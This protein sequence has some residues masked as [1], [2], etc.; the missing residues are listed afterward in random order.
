MYQLPVFPPRPV[1][2]AGHLL[3]KVGLVLSC[4]MLNGPSAL[5]RDLLAVY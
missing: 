4:F 3:T 2:A 5:T 1:G